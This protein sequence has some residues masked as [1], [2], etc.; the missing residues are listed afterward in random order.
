MATIRLSDALTAVYDALVAALEP[1]P[2]GQP[3]LTIDLGLNPSAAADEL[4]IIVGHDGTLNPDGS[5]SEAAEAGTL[6]TKFTAMGDPP[7]QQEDGVL[8]VVVV[9]QTGDST[10]LAGRI[11]EAQTL[12]EGCNDACADLKVGADLR[13]DSAGDARLYTRQSVAGCAAEFAFSFTYSAP[14]D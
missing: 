11:A 3:G 4:F 2:A 9:A 12:L 5:L 7:L 13:I 1:T 8:H 14:W 10:D 6:N